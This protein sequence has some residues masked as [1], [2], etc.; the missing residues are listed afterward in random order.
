[1]MKRSQPTPI[2]DP[3]ARLLAEAVELGASDLHLEPCPEGLAVRLRV[4]GRFVD[5]PPA[6]GDAA[7][8]LIGR[9]KV[10]AEL[11]VYR[12]DVPQEGRLPLPNGREG[13]LAL[14]P[15]VRGEKATLRFFADD[16][17]F[18][19]IGDLGLEAEHRERLGR[20]LRRDSGLILVVGPSGSGKTTTLYSALQTII[21]ERGA[22][23]QLC[24]I[25]DPV[26]RHLQG[27]TQVEV[28]PV[29]GL[30]FA[31]GLKFLLRQDPEVVMVG[32]VRDSETARVAVRAAMTGHLVLSTLHCGRAHEARP[33]LLEMGV[34][35]YAVDLG[36]VGV[37]AQR[38]LRRLCP[39]CGGSGCGACLDSGYRGR[40][41][42]SEV[43]GGGETE[44]SPSLVEVGRRRMEAGLT[45]REE[46]ERVLGGGA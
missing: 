2:L 25:E 32:E 3:A 34:P 41:L 15:T 23:C 8:R 14:I 16:R 28:S 46:I 17:R 6:L 27:C 19:S 4:D 10:M 43:L 30:D 9:L 13:R 45:T 5:R 26:E 35:E 33:R 42:V 36:F 39:D 29:R 12:S 38:L 21:D 31:A 18:S 11:M 37:V 40:L 20:L 7:E 24:S 22:F 44:P 1:M